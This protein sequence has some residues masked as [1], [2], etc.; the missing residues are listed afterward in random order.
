M[1]TK[2]IYRRI[3]SVNDYEKEGIPETFSSF[4]LYIMQTIK[5]KELWMI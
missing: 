3:L 5:T 4:A 2:D 1:I